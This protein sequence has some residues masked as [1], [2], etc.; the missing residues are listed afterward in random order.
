MDANLRHIERGLWILMLLLVPLGEG[1]ATPWALFGLQ[2]L[3]FLAGWLRLLEAGTSAPRAEMPR[4][5]LL[6]ASGFLCVSLAACWSSPYPYASFLRWWDFA[7]LG[8]ILTLGA[9]RTWAERE[10]NLLQDCVLAAA[11]LQAGMVLLGTMLGTTST[12]LA[13]FGLFNSN[14]EAAYLL[15]AA[16]LTAPRLSFSSPGAGRFLRGGSVLLCM[17]AFCLLMS[18][19]ALLGLVAGAATLL[20]LQWRSLSKRSR[21]V[22][23]AAAVLILF[24]AA[25]GVA[26]R[27]HSSEDPYRFERFRIWE[28]DL[29]C[30]AGAPLLGVGP[31]IYRHVAKRFNF[32]LEGPVRFG[33]NFET[34]HSD[35]LG[36]MVETGLAGLTAGLVLLG[37][38]LKHLLDRRRSGETL[39]PGLLAGCSALATHG[40]V[41]DL[42]LRPALMVTL[43]VLVGASLSGSGRTAASRCVVPR[44][45]RSATTALAAALAL[46]WWAAVLD[47]YRAILR[48]QAMRHS[49]SYESMESEFRLAVRCNP[50]QAITYRFPS[51]AF[52][53]THPP[54]RLSLELYARFR[55]DLDRGGL[56]DR[57]S[58][59][60][61]LT[62]ARLEARAFRF[63]FHDSATRDR[64]LRAYR[65]AILLAPHDPRIRV[66]LASFLLEV[67]RGRPAVEELDRA[68]REE[69]DYLTAQLLKARILLDL[70]DRGEAQR[71]WRQAGK[72][73]SLLATYRADSGYA[74][75]VTRD[76][77]ALRESLERDLGPS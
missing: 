46:L 3:V 53:A 13:R 75:D 38:T 49:T 30:F 34:A 65:A 1:G 62:L 24:V 14:H 15:F 19:G 35:Y 25:A 66:E 23:G 60:L 73:R 48:D 71:S 27:F 32:P 77:G 41:E 67:G 9:G 44:G 74:M 28:A 55:R 72:I 57:T 11:S 42:S 68:L 22:A 64:V 33:R 37:F 17:L 36:Q 29:R 56:M 51:G 5:V 6:A 58:P 59:D 20:G 40:L 31:G 47:P 10:K 4:S 54:A 61:R 63:L 50:Y 26:T 21:I 69:P 39:A 76:P 2:S 12:M 16:L 8:A 43:A 18:R 70:G 7:I 45:L 52:L